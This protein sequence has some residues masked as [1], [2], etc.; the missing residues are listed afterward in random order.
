MTN[1]G[2]MK[3]FGIDRD[4]FK[5]NGI[6]DENIN[7]IYRALYVYSLGFPELVKEPLNRGMNKKN[8]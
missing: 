8:Y 5:N 1:K 6:D 2:V 7:R 3:T 4:T